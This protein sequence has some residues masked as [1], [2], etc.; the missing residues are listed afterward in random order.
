[1]VI[2]SNKNRVFKS[3]LSCSLS[4]EI[5]PYDNI[6]VHETKP[7]SGR[8]VHPHVVSSPSSQ[9][10]VEALE[11]ADLEF[12]CSALFPSIAAP[13]LRRMVTFNERLHHETMVAHS[14]GHKGAPWEFNLRDIL[15]WC[16][17]ILSAREE[18]PLLHAAASDDAAAG[19]HL[20]TI[21]VQRMRQPEDRRRTL[22]LF[23]DIF[24]AEPS[25][26]VHPR[27]TLT[28]QI[29]Q[30]GRTAIP[31]I[32]E[33]GQGQAGRARPLA[34]MQGQLSALETVARCVQRG[35][36]SILLG[37]PASGKTSLVRTLAQ[38]TGNA[39]HEYALTSASDTTELLGCFEQVRVTG[40]VFKQ[41]RSF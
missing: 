32:Q 21:Y 13:T 3:F 31:R 35:W 30:I 28:P 9:V 14:F 39:L 11:A 6:H 22:G 36:M 38:L 17:L 2:D 10:Y 12:I 18:D 37:G 25:L 16:E 8:T 27:L 4:D 33:P 23:R 29:L 20:G 15:R 34:V 1:V 41:G 26:D 19:R 7:F 40:G 5:R 24:G